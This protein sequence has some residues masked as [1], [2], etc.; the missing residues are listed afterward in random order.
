MRTI[1]ETITGKGYSFAAD[2]NAVVIERVVPAYL[3]NSTALVEINKQL[4]A[5]VEKVLVGCF[6]IVCTVKQQFLDLEIFLLMFV[7][8]E[9]LVPGL[10]K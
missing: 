8:D 1:S 9:H 7:S 3:F 5:T 10:N 4:C 6:V 2:G